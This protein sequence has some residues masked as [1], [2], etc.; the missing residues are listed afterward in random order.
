M[1]KRECTPG[2]RKSEYNGSE[3]YM[4]M[5]DTKCQKATG[6]HAM[7]CDAMHLGTVGTFAVVLGPA[8]QGVAWGPLGSGGTGRPAE[9]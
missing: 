6:P 7:R 1:G 5:H 4:W 2:R 3:A 8:W 9:A